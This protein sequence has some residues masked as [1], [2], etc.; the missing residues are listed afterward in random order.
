M[1]II[2]LPFWLDARGTPLC[3]RL[4]H[5]LRPLRGRLTKL[6]NAVGLLKEAFQEALEMRRA[7]H[8]SFHPMIED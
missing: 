8:T 7:A 6:K 3:G 2:R 5:L 1:L 4:V